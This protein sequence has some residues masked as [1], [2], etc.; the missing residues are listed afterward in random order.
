MNEIYNYPIRD[1]WSLNSKLTKC[2]IIGAGNA[3]NMNFSKDEKDKLTKSASII[4]DVINK[5]DFK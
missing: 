4:Y 1:I 5:I 3:I 2:L